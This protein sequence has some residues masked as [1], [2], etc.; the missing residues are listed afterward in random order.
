[1]YSFVEYL[2]DLFTSFQANTMSVG[3]LFYDNV[4]NSVSFTCNSD[5][6][7]YLH[8]QCTGNYLLVASLH[9]FE[10]KKF[11]VALSSF[12]LQ[13]NNDVISPLHKCPVCVPVS[14][15]NPDSFFL[16]TSQTFFLSHDFE[17]IGIRVRAGSL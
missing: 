14:V 9:S 4:I 7:T 10:T 6:S 3:L 1:M 17:M 8:S 11:G 5:H 2:R 12:H 16:Q 15:S 13:V